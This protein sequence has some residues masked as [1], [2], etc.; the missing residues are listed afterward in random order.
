MITKLTTNVRCDI[1][2]C[3]NIATHAINIKGRAQRLYLCEHCL[4]QIALSAKPTPP[5]SPK[6]T[7]K[8]KQDETEAQRNTAKE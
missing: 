3:R 7:I 2:D 5:R 1:R 6:N 4:E 8:R